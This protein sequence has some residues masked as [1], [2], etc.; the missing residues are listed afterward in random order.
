MATTYPLSVARTL[1]LYA[2]GDNGSVRHRGYFAFTIDPYPFLLAVQIAAE[3]QRSRL[4]GTAG[5][6][7]DD[8]Y[9]QYHPD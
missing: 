8:H 5:R 1:A 7:T 9:Q 6:Q 3:F 4:P 2:Q